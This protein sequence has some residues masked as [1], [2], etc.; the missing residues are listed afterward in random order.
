MIPLRRGRPLDPAAGVLDAGRPLG[1]YVHFPF[2][3]VRCPYC[4]FAVDTRAA[5]PHDEYARVVVAE[6][7]ARRPWFLGADG[8]PPPLRSIYFGG[9]TP[10]LWRP[11]ALGQVLAAV[12][13]A[14]AAQD[15]ELEV[16][17]EANPGEVTF[18]GL[19]ALRGLGVDRL[20]LGVQSFDDRLLA[21]VGRNHQASAAAPAV[22]GGGGGGVVGRARDQ[23]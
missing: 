21:A 2:C 19:A 15:S 5:I 22:A 3:S 10:G 1:V 16:T 11:E 17:V 9:G 23:V 18:E 4:D 6:I 13:R 20:S 7:E 14:F 8:S 12:R